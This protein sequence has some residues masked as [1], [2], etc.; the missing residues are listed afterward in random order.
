M[1]IHL[2]LEP[3]AKLISALQRAGNREIGGILM[4]EHVREGE[5]KIVDLTIQ[6]Q[7]GAFA[8]FIRKVSEAAIA[9]QGFFSKTKHSYTRFNYIGEWHSHPQFSLAPSQ[10]DIVS[11]MDIVNDQ[12]VGANFAILFIVKLINDRDLAG[13]ATVFLPD[14]IFESRVIMEKGSD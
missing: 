11:M 7:T 12:E 5:F 10:K 6:S 2:L 8:H 14:A 1:R 13:S 4:G 9:L 3:Q